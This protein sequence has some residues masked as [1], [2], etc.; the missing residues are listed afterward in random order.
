M[1]PAN[2]ALRFLLE[3]AALAGFAVFAWSWASGVWRYLAAAALVLVIGVLWATFAVPDDPSRSGHAPV[4][5]SGVVRLILELLLLLGGAVALYLAGHGWMALLLA[6]LI[7]VHYGFSI[8]RLAWLL[9]KN[10]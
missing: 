9:E 4:P 8:E 6:A 3:L 10:E 7:A 2:L 5:V 1:H